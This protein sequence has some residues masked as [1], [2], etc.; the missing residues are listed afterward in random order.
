ML[1]SGS[2]DTCESHFW[3]RLVPIILNFW[4]LGSHLQ[5]TLASI[6]HFSVILH[7]TLKLIDVW[8]AILLQ[9]VIVQLSVEV[10]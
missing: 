8:V 10:G 5:T 4:Q 3:A 7:V 6:M 2:L 9:C 1:L